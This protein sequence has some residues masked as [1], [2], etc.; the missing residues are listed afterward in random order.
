MTDIAPLTPAHLST[1]LDLNNRYSVEMSSLDEAA[2]QSLVAQSWLALQADEGRA[3]FLI[4]LD[5]QASYDSPNFAWFAERY[6]NFAYIDR[7]AIAPGA[8]GQGLARR[9]YGIA[10]AKARAAQLPVLVC[11][12][13]IVPPNIDSQAFHKAL[14]F[15]EIGQGLLAGRGKTVQY[16]S[17]SLA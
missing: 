6:D 17:K 4:T 3:G 16:L 7:I 10:E 13:N 14:G 5:H 12:V 15:T 9:F 2:L 1:V 8:Q 11:E